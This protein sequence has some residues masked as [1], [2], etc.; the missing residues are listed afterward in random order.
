MPPKR[1]ERGKSAFIDN[2]DGDRFSQ[3][4]KAKTAPITL[5]PMT[6]NIYPI[7]EETELNLTDDS[8]S[9]ALNGDYKEFHHDITDTSK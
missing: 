5:I 4:Q 6:R 9:L 2:G 3:A 1:R 7:Q 8:D